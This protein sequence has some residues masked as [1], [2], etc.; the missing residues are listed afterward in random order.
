[1]CSFINGS[2]LTFQLDFI[3]GRVLFAVVS[4]NESCAYAK[5]LKSHHIALTHNPDT[6]P[7]I[8]DGYV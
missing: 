6:L 5:D 2:Y 1:M 8:Q 3:Y 4:C 7:R